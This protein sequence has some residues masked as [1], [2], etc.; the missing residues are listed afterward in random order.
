MF[1]KEVA[2]LMSKRGDLHLFERLFVI[3]WEKQQ[4]W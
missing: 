1:C 2:Q 3:G 4:G